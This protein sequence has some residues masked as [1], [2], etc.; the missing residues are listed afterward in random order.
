MFCFFF[1]LG[2]WRGC[3]GGLGSWVVVVA[4]NLQRR[5]FSRGGTQATLLGDHTAVKQHTPDV[6]LGP[7]MQLCVVH[8]VLRYVLLLG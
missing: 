1:W 7:P 8:R 3:R 6:A 4:N 2:E 5:N